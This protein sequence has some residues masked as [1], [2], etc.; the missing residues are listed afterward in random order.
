MVGSTTYYLHEDALGSTRLETTSTVTIKFSSNYIPY[1]SNYAVSGKEVFMY[2]GKPY[3]SATGLY[4]EGARY[5]DPT[6]GRFIT[7]DSYPGSPADPLSMNLYVYARDNPERYT[8]PDGHVFIDEGGVYYS[9]SGV[10]LKAEGVIPT[11]PKTDYTDIRKVGYGSIT[12]TPP[13]ITGGASV[14]PPDVTL[15]SQG[16]CQYFAPAPSTRP[17]DVGQGW[18]R[19]ASTP[20]IG[21]GDGGGTV[22]ASWISPPS[23]SSPNPLAA[24]AVVAAGTYGFQALEGDAFNAAVYNLRAGSNASPSGV[25]NHSGIPSQLN[26]VGSSII[27][28]YGNMLNGW[29]GMR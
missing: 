13:P 17:G 27:S 14:K 24:W 18:S 15:T 28:L 23:P 6:T 5:Y 3:D 8:D 16:N 4:Y 11:T 10:V 7:Q 22:S 19:P 12:S 2:T 25:W 20:T 29:V 9:P 21:V 1:G 26:S